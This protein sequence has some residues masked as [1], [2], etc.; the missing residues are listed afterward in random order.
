MESKVCHNSQKKENQFRI[1]RKK[2]I[3]Q[4]VRLLPQQAWE[5]PARRLCKA[6]GV[7][8]PGPAKAVGVS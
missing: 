5:R 8:W 4:H 2:A 3:R 6:R 7:I 1:L